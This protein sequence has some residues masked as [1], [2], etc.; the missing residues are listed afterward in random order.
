[1]DTPDLDRI[2]F[3]T[4]HFDDLQG[5]RYR[6]PLGLITLSLGG[7]V[8]F[9]NPPLVLLRAVLFAGAV[10]LMIFARRYYRRTFGE[11]EPWPMEE[12]AM[13]LS[14]FRSAGQAGQ[15]AE[16]S[17][18]RRMTPRIRR[19]SIILGLTITLLAVLHALGP[20]L[21]IEQEE[22]L[23]QPPWQTLG[24]VFFIDSEDM[25]LS[26]SASTTKT[27]VAQSIYALFGSFS[28]GLWLW[29]ECR[30]SQS[31]HLAFGALLLGLAAVGAG[32]GLLTG[33]AETGAAGEIALFA[34]PFLPAALHLWVAL[35]LCGSAMVLA[36]LF[37]HRQLV[38][39]LR[40]QR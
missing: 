2:R 33:A 15:A 27:L 19:F 4:R 36:G 21:R 13:E 14:V 35:L 31:V 24:S 11:V 20:K 7:T 18:W 3:V 38:R 22:S 23:A 28:L 8:Y 1:M 30:P 34:N 16:L 9:S 29:R 17:G 40:R 12:P 39:A 6:V 32:A 25:P 37:D 10:L 5:L 26:L